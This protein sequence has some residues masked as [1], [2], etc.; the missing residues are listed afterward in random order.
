MSDL[1]VATGMLLPLRS[2]CP[3]SS[4]SQIK[5][6][7]EQAKTRKSQTASQLQAP[8][9]RNH[10]PPSLYFWRFVWSS[11]PRVLGTS[12]RM[13]Q[14]QTENYNAEENL[15]NKLLV[16]ER[17]SLRNQVHSLEAKKL[18]LDISN[19]NLFRVAKLKEVAD[20]SALKKSL[21]KKSESWPLPKSASPRK[22]KEKRRKREDEEN[23]LE[24]PTGLLRNCRAEREQKIEGTGNANNKD[25]DRDRASSAFWSGHRKYLASLL[26]T[27]VS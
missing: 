12:E 15:A 9:C 6:N 2:P 8:N 13:R 25:W 21:G 17:T 11:W 1:V 5:F 10:R 4:K 20:L 27:I 14:L 19:S 26:Q 24:E 22:L 7:T 18:Q 3:G 16:K 23:T